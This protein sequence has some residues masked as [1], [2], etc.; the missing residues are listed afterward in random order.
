MDQSNLS[1][2][3]EIQSE[4]QGEDLAEF[5]TQVKQWLQIDEEISKYQKKIKELKKAKKSI[6]EPTITA[7]MVTYNIADLNTEQGKIRCNEK[8]TKKPL[9]KKNIE[10]NLA[11]VITDEGQIN[12]AMQLIMNNR[13][14][15]K[16]YVLTKPKQKSPTNPKTLD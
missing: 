7:F 2:Q 6:L 10:D 4:I 11:Q 15:V 12:Q 1:E 16:T 5:K 13:E 8:N 3:G 9:N 14:T